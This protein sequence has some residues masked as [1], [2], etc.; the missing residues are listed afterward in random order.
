MRF[1]MI[2][3]EYPPI[4]AG[5]ANATWH[6]SRCLI[7]QGH[8]VGVLTSRFARHRGWS[9]EEGVRI[10]RCP[11]RRAAAERSN[12]VEMSSFMVGGALALPHVVRKY[13][14]DACIAFF[15]IPGGPIALLG[16]LL[17]RLPYAVSLRGGDVPG[18][19]FTLKWTHRIMKPLRRMILRR[20]HAVIANS[21]GLKRLTESVD[22]YP[23]S[24]IS[25]GV[26]AHYFS[27]AAA[28]KSDATFRTLF[29]GR[30]HPQKNVMGMVEQF[31]AAAKKLP[32]TPMHLELVGDGPE[33]GA[34]EALIER[35]GIASQVTLRGWLPR[36]E[37]LEAYR[38]ADC[39]VNPSIGEGLPNVV[40]EAMACGIAVVA[41]RVPGNDT[42]VKQGENGLLFDVRK[43][44]ELCDALVMLAQDTRQRNDMGARGREIALAEYSWDSVARKYAQLFMER[45]K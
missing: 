6:I 2:N 41:S 36:G 23:A 9:T 42:L 18:S 12:I 14:P 15:S 11:A 20:S 3:Y 13:R 7:A 29:V 37:L 35:L 30:F 31:A 1:L 5:A 19:E 33:R 16:N 38:R 10:Y 28:P 4:G 24:V 32:N 27:P 8:E 43:P 44:R 34:A 45:T 22:P 25:S 17:W 26:D 40:L 39:L 21:E